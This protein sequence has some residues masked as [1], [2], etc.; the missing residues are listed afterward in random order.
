MWRISKE[1]LI[2]F[3]LVPFLYHVCHAWP[4]T[5]PLKM[6]MSLSTFCKFCE[7]ENVTSHARRSFSFLEIWTTGYLPLLLVLL[8]II[9]SYLTWINGCSGNYLAMVRQDMH[10]YAD[11]AV[12]LAMKSVM[13]MLKMWVH[14]RTRAENNPTN[15]YQSKVWYLAMVTQTIKCDF[16]TLCL[17]TRQKS[18]WITNDCIHCSLPSQLTKLAKSGI[19]HCYLQWQCTRS[20]VTYM[21]Q[22]YGTLLKIKE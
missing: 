15:H 4:S 11:I 18:I 1:Q 12:S 22:V 9:W 7:S 21:M 5:L 13:D 2:F 8:R 20:C 16:S 3:P 6:T 10:G 14:K 19:S 17:I